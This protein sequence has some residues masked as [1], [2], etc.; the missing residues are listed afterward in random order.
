MPDLSPPINHAVHAS[1][2]QELS[3]LTELGQILSSTLELR[4]TFGRMMQ[5]ISDKLN[6]R[7]GTLVLL[8]ESTGRLRTEAAV[9][10]TSDEMDR[11][12]YAL[13]EGITGNVVATGRPRIVADV[14]KEPDFLNRTG[15]FNPST[16]EGQISFLC[17]PIKIEGRTTGALS[18]DKPFSSD[19]HLR[20][21]YRFLDIVAAFLSQAIQINRMVMRQKEELLEENAQLRAQVRDRYRFE[22]IIGDSPAMHEVFATVGQVANSRATVLLLGETGTGKEMIA[23]A[24]HYNSPRR[25]KPFIRVNCGAMT[26]T[27][28]ESELFGHVKGSF[29]GAIKDKIGRFEAADGGSIFLDEIGTMEPQLQVKLLRVLQER[30]LE[31]VGDTQTLK[32]DVR[33]IAATNVDL[34]EEVARDNFRED[35]F[36]RLNVVSIYLPPLR[37]RREDIPRLIDFF[38]DKYNAV[39]DR[40]LRRISREMLNILL[41]YPW[42]GNVRELE[43][44]IERAV[45]L[46]SGEDFTED[47]LPLSVRM[48]AAQRRTNQASES[49]ETLTRRLSDQAIADYELREGEIY[50]LVMDQIER[51]LIDRALAKCGGI[52]TKAADFLGINRNTLNKKVKDLGIEAVE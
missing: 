29:T 18:V 35:L 12:K 21:D 50:Q 41:R 44:A 9:G 14:R 10:L 5:I 46:S 1:A 22:N 49:I 2:E 34:Q 13:G 32:V 8:D 24:I 26:T 36:Y 28:L 3:I 48:F 17:V 6:M 38:L 45:V 4:D 51:A 15:R 47:L 30:E 37:N 23:K 16:D 39:N 19:E 25:D 20:S 40:R 43:N 11:G 52:K 7:R 31:R 33:V 42:P 27:L